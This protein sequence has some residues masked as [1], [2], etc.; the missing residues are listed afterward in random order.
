MKQ[1]KLALYGL[2]FVAVYLMSYVV[3]STNGFYEPVVYGLLKGR[4][5]N[6]ILAPKA[7]FGYR[8]QAY[9]FNTEQG[10]TEVR[11]VTLLYLPILSL[12]RAVW[13]TRDRVHTLRYRTKNY[14]DFEKLEYMDVH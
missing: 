5:G 3:V 10:Y 9:G 11:W 12:D 13:H 7:A 2:I 8:W 4:D 14:F 6:P 1:R